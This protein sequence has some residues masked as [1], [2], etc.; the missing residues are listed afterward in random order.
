MSSISFAV[1]ILLIVLVLYVAAFFCLKARWRF[2][3]VICI[4]LCI[5]ACVIGFNHLGRASQS[6]EMTYTRRP[7]YEREL[8]NLRSSKDIHGEG[9]FSSQ[10]SLLS[11]TAIGEFSLGSY[12]TFRYAYRDD[13]GAIRF[14]SV[15]IKDAIIYDNLA[16]GEAPYIVVEQVFGTRHIRLTYGKIGFIQ[17]KDDDMVSEPSVVGMAYAIYVSPGTITE[18]LDFD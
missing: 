16:E 10:G 7:F 6:T 15:S 2:L 11:N 3:G 5:T 4:V 12:D 9:T 1:L 14:E 17:I 18:Y 8:I 13:S